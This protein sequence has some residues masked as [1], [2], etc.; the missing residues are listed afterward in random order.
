[1]ALVAKS[2]RPTKR[3]L[4]EFVVRWCQDLRNPPWEQYFGLHRKFN[5]WAFPDAKG[6][7]YNDVS[8]TLHIEDSQLMLFL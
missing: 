5:L 8:L 7:P 6:R 1:M 4:G 2:N 3:R